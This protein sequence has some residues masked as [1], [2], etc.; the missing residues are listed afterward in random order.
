M[1]TI[2]PKIFAKLDFLP[3]CLEWVLRILHRKYFEYFCCFPN[4]ALLTQF[5]SLK[6]L[7]KKQNLFSVKDNLP[8]LL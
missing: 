5:L 3:Q 2:C 4:F 1:R 8:V 7:K 6:N